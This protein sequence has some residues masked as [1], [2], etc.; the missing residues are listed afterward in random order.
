M[1]FGLTWA[2]LDEMEYVTEAEK[3][4]FKRCLVPK[5]SKTPRSTGVEVLTA[6][7]LDEAIDVALGR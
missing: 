6:R 3:L 1:E 4:G 7:S 5:S 2:K